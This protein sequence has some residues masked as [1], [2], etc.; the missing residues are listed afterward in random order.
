M[1]IS[2]DLSLI[3]KRLQNKAPLSE[4]MGLNTV[5]SIQLAKHNTATDIV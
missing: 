1:Q 3:P 4:Y 5:M 2:V